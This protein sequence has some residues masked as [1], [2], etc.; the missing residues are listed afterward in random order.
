MIAAGWQRATAA[1]RGGR[2]HI[3]VPWKCDYPDRERIWDE[4]KKK[5]KK[6]K[7]RRGG[8]MVDQLELNI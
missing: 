7:R 4:G 8:K 6:K 5:G 2:G 1:I 3:R